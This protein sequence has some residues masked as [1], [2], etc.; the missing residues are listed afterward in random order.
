MSDHKHSKK[1][2]KLQQIANQR[3]RQ[4]LQQ[5]ADDQARS[6]DLEKEREEELRESMAAASRRGQQAGTKV[7]DAQW[8][9]KLD[10]I[11]DRNTGR[12]RVAADRWNRFAG[13]A[14]AGGRGL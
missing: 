1:A 12:A 7:T 5:M 8:K 6:R 3:H 10:V 9:R 13:T 4:Q 11:R 2:K 14:G